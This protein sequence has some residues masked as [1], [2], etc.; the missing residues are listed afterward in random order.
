MS[1]ETLRKL[2]RRFRETG[3]VEDEAL[4]LRARVQAGDLDAESLA[5]ATYVDPAL[6]GPQEAGAP[7]RD[8]REWASGL[9]EWGLSACVRVAVAAGQFSARHFLALYPG[10]PR[11][12]QA[13]SAVEEW[14]LDP[15]EERRL[16][17]IAARS[18]CAHAHREIIVGVDHLVAVHSAAL[19]ASSVATSCGEWAEWA[20]AGTRVSATLHAGGACA[21]R[22]VS[23]AARALLALRKGPV[24]E[25]GWGNDEVAWQ[26]C[27]Q[28][29]RF[30]LRAELVPW[31]LGYGDPVRDRVEARQ[32]VEATGE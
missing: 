30:A 24:L 17:V 18:N 6:G 1:D 20:V 13:L 7:P 19:S 2:E 31:A 14:L 27:L 25:I 29:V 12:Q 8:W 15:S 4:W 3:C 21:E 9:K 11:V 22:A 32:R 26:E 16:A 28:V 5:L 10:D 23:G